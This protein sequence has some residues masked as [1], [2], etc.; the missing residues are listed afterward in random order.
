MLAIGRLSSV[1]GMGNGGRFGTVAVSS[2]G[3]RTA[4]EAA[5]SDPDN[6]STIRLSI[7]RKQE[8]L[9]SATNRAKK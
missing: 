9:V 7:L 4:V 3:T 2:S 8:R 1:E 6:G 5:K